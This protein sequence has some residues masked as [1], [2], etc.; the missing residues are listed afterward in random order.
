MTIIH[1]STD[2]P[3]AI[4]PAKTKAISNLVES[5][6]DQFDHQIYSLNRVDL[7]PHKAL[8]RWLSKGFD[9]GFRSH[10]RIGNITSWQYAAMPFGGFLKS[11]LEALGDAIADDIIARKLSPTL[12]HGHKL[13]MEGIIANRVAKR[14]GVPFGL[15]LQGNTDRRILGV[16][17][18]LRGMYRHIYHDA[19][20]IFPF[21]PWIKSYCDGYLGETQARCHILPCM[22]MNDDMMAPSFM[23][24]NNA[25]RAQKA[26]SAFHLRH[27][28]LK[29]ADRLIAVAGKVGARRKDFS[30]EIAGGGTSEHEAILQRFISKTA[31]SHAELIGAVNGDDIQQWMNSG[32]VFVMPSRRETFGLVFVEALMAGCPVIYPKDAAIDGY[33][34]GYGFARAV[35]AE[36]IDEIAAV[37]EEMLDNEQALKEELVIWQ[38]SDH[39]QQ[40]RRKNIAAAFA[41]GLLHA[42]TLGQADVN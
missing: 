9:K 33:F 41:G 16:R 25:R 39:A 6:A 8:W 19:A 24:D 36:D 1:I 32:S 11:T 26:V 18:D 12:I 23:S 34:E 27:W 17:R 5:T 7:A 4:E 30:L 42:A 28:H 3:D 21:A 40:F 37:L 10:G 2:Y 20:I 22:T 38:D 15:S 29:N 13:S 31:Q 35:P 14:L